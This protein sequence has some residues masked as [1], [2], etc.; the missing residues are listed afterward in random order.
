[1]NQDDTALTQ[2]TDLL[3]SG[4]LNQQGM[5]DRLLALVY[6]QL[7]QL[8]SQQM[9]NERP[10]HTLTPT[11]LVHESFLR[12]FNQHSINWQSKKHFYGAVAESMRRILVESARA[13]KTLKR[14]GGQPHLFNIDIPDEVDIHDD[15]V[16]LDT[17]LTT[18]EQKDET[19]AQVV[20]LRYFSGLNIDQV[21]D[22]LEISPRTV[23]RQWSAAR[24]WLIT[25]MR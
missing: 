2:I 23:N 14:G 4:A 25:Q 1:M 21:A 19:M 11:A 16:A 18:L 22:L 12:L 10:N 7:K 6:N 8:A 9:R 17:A 5:Q 3:N 20:K 15:L 24:A 13:K